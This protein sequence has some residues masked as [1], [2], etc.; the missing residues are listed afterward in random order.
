MDLLSSLLELLERRDER[1]RAASQREE[2]KCTGLKHFKLQE[3][4][5]YCHGQ[6]WGKNAENDP[7]RMEWV[8]SEQPV[9][10]Y[11]KDFPRGT[12]ALLW[13]ETYDIGAPILPDGNICWCD[14]TDLYPPLGYLV[15]HQGCFADIN[16]TDV[17]AERMDRLGRVLACMD[18]ESIGFVKTKYLRTMPDVPDFRHDSISQVGHRLG[19][20]LGYLPLET[21]R[22]I[23]SY[24]GGA[25]FWQ[26]VKALDFRYCLNVMRRTAML[27]VC[28]GEVVKWTRG[29]DSPI[30]SSSNASFGF[31]RITFDKRGLYRIEQLPS[32]RICLA[33]HPF[34]RFMILEL[35]LC[36][37]I[38][39][40]FKVSSLR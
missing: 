17:S 24:C 36:G 39:T 8:P 38:K 3:E 16:G 5:A 23:Q 30:L 33:K 20:P 13:N 34:R 7:D 18:S 9:V 2:S 19:L 4:C 32:L 27:S 10:M 6:I 25:P 31:V 12:W 1:P 28:L 11:C 40:Y 14:Q 29:T 35:S 15:L 22:H 37:T 21:L 26:W